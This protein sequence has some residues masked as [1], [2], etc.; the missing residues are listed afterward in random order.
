MNKKK[1]KKQ[2]W[3]KPKLIVLVRGDASEAVLAACKIGADGPTAKFLTCC[4]IVGV[5]HGINCYNC[6]S[7]AA[8]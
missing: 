3:G 2:V 4:Q 8:S 5:I 1:Q 6:D 7:I